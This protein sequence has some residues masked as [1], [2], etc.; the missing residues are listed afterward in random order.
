MVKKCTTVHLTPDSTVEAADVLFILFIGWERRQLQQG[1]LF[2]AVASGSGAARSVRSVCHEGCKGEDGLPHGD[3][4]SVRPLEPWRADKKK[5]DLRNL[6]L[7]IWSV[8]WWNSAKSENGTIAL[9]PLENWLFEA[10]YFTTKHRGLCRLSLILVLG[11]KPRY[12]LQWIPKCPDSKSPYFR[13]RS[14]KQPQKLDEICT[15]KI[16]K[17][18]W[19]PTVNSS[20]HPPCCAGC[21]KSSTSEQTFRRTS[22]PKTKRGFHPQIFEEKHRKTC[23]NHQ[24]KLEFDQ[25]YGCSQP[26]R[27]GFHHQEDGFNQPKRWIYQ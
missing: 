16:P 12:L 9:V 20:L 17:S 14:K 4:G 8:Q 18:P 22:S 3:I 24:G 11:P 26:R 6:Q 21:R 23:G 1:R 15:Q 19:K 25:E 13:W 27:W 5:H 2:V 10:M 7:A